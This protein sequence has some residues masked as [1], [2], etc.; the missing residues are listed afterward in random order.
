MNL[1][2]RLLTPPRALQIGEAAKE[3]G[4][5][6][7]SEVDP[8]VSLEAFF[9]NQ[10]DKYYYGVAVQAGYLTYESDLGGDDLP[11]K[12]SIRVP[13]KELLYVW[14]S[15][16][17]SEIVNDQNNQLGSIFARIENM[18]RF[19]RDLSEFISLKLSH[20]DLAKNLGPRTVEQVYHV[21][22]FGMMLTLGYECHSNRE[23]GLGRYDLLVKAPQWTAA[24]EFKVS[25]TKSGLESAAREGLKQIR[26]N[27][28]LADA[29]RD[30]PAYAIGVGCWK[31]ACIVITEKV[32]NE[33][34]LA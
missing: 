16:I 10:F 6:F 28:Y 9:G 1:L 7:I 5:V 29:T 25:K 26:D 33:R 30:K 31:K 17:L 3:L 34:E 11:R 32:S 4:A 20:H 2:G 22:V 8:R 23:A 24:I 27:E 19:N 18:E 13:N 12:Y 14:R 21:F 15:Y